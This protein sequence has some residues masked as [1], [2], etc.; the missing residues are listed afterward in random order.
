MSA[1]GWKEFQHRRTF[2]VTQSLGTNDTLLYPKKRVFREIR[3]LTGN[4]SGMWNHVAS[5]HLDTCSSKVWR[6]S[7]QG[8]WQKWCVVYQEVVGLVS[9]CLALS[10][11]YSESPSPMV[12]CFTLSAEVAFHPLI[13]LTLVSRKFQ[14]QTVRSQHAWHYQVTCTQL[15]HVGRFVIEHSCFL[16]LACCIPIICTIR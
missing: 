12:G 2:P 5:H 8:K 1:R 7:I 11:F 6:K 9:C 15:Q 10:V 3:P 14:M 13:T 4:F 16:S